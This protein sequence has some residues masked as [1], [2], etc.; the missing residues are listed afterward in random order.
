MTYSAMHNVFTV[1]EEATHAPTAAQPGLLPPAAAFW[2]T[3]LLAVIL[4]ALLWQPFGYLAIPIALL[5]GRLMALDLTTYTLP[6]IYTIPLL[7]VGLFHA[8]SHEQLAQ[9][10]IAC[11]VIF[12]FNKTMAAANLRMARSVGVGGGD[13]KLLAALFAFMP[14]TTGFWAIAAG[15]LLYMPVAFAKP[16]ATVPFGVPLIMGWVVLLRWPH[17][18]NWL[19]STIS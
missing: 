4:G 5:F 12:F 9:A 16:K 14:L 17:L 6:N 7:V 3:G 15:C 10:F 2:L 11:V 19:I 18:P 1:W 13:L 8:L